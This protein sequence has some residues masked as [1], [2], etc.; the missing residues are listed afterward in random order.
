MLAE[1]IRIEEFYEEGGAEGP[2]EEYESREPLQYFKV[3][4]NI[5]ERYNIWF[6]ILVKGRAKYTMIYYLFNL[7]FFRS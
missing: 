4:Y 3:T 2:V 6:V 5:Q 7:D 1:P